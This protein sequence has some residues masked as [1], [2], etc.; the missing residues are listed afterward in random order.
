[1]GE[2]KKGVKEGV[3]ILKT[4]QFLLWGKFTNNQFKHSSNEVTINSKIRRT[5]NN[6]NNNNNAL[7]NNPI[8]DVNKTLTSTVNSNALKQSAP[9]SNNPSSKEGFKLSY[10]S[11]LIYTA[12][13]IVIYKN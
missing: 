1:M 13:D 11:L 12:S 2:F 8:N 5:T 7:I 6:N 9:N 10:N 3:G 4:N